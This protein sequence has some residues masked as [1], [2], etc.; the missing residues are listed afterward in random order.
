MKNMFF[1]GLTSVLATIAK[2]IGASLILISI[3][4]LIGLQV[5]IAFTTITANI[6]PAA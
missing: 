4:S 6:P 5:Y 2:F 3:A 1:V